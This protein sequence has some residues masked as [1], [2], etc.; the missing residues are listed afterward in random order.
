VTRKL[1]VSLF[2][3]RPQSNGN[4]NLANLVV[5]VNKIVE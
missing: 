2:F 5:A 1:S 4:D 3:V